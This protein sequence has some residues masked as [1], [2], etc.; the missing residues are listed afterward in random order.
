MWI[1]PLK[2]IP[3]PVKQ[4]RTDRKAAEQTPEPGQLAHYQAALLADINQLKQLRDVNEKAV[5][6]AKAV[7]A[8]LGFIQDYIDNDER[9]P[10]SVAVQV[11]IWLFDCGETMKGLSLALH[12]IRQGLHHTPTNFGRNLETFVCDSVYDWAAALLKNGTY[13]ATA[14]ET[15]VAEME[16]GNW[17]ALMPQ[18]V[19]GKMYAMLA[20]HKNLL[21]EFSAALELCYKAEAANPD[22]AGVKTLIDEL[23]R[24][25]KPETGTAALS[26]TE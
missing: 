13:A 8:Y 6:K 12:L 10:N 5:Y 9:Y 16:S 7:P 23:T 15:T 4:K 3:A 26:E 18:V 24:K 19:T 2:K 25:L 14:L 22:K 20:K 1:N 21:G 11:M 17:Q